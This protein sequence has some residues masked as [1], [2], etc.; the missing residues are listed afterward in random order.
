MPSSQRVSW[1]SPYQPHISQD[2]GS[3]HVVISMLRQKGGQ[4]S[5]KEGCL[6]VTKNQKF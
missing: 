3:R 2:V 4:E 6:S 1:N 5:N